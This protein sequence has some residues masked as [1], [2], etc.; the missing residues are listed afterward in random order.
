[1]PS[2]LV[3]KSHQLDAADYLAARPRAL[4]ADPPGMMKTL[5]VIHGMALA[6]VEHPLIVC[7][8]VV[9]THWRRSLEDYCNTYWPTFTEA[10]C[11]VKSY[12]EIVR[13]GTR[14][15]AD[16]LLTRDMLHLDEFHFCKH[17]SAQRTQ[18]LLGRDGYA[19]NLPIV[20]GTSGTPMDKTPT[21]I[22]T[23]LSSFFPALA[24]E[25]GVPSFR[26][27]VDRF[28]VWEMRERRGKKFPHY[29]P[30]TKEPEVFAELLSRMWLRRDSI[31]GVPAIF[32]VLRLDGSDHVGLDYTAQSDKIATTLG[33]A[34]LGAML[35]EEA[36]RLVMQDPETAR[37]RR[38]LG[39]HKVAPV[40]ALVTSE[41][42]DSDEKICVFAHHRSVL[43]GLREGLAKFGVAYIDGSVP[44]AARDAEIA[45]FI[46]E[47]E[48][49][50]FIGQN[51]A[52]GTGL[53]GLQKSGARRMLLVE[54][55]YSAVLNTQLA[56]RLAR[57]GQ[58][59]STVIAQM[60]AL[61]GTLDEGIV[62]LF[63]RETQFLMEAGL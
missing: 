57:F 35:D 14:M 53:D 17:A 9:R 41:L 25:Y 28:A 52:C 43:A 3:L 31:P 13:G 23:I 7:P 51:D 34:D 42:T 44:Q 36:I 16:L 18:L 15:Q 63:H 4:L 29:F 58:E 61:A 54:P 46:N 50:I 6:G 21:N 24:I 12:D 33:M 45:R 11:V 60:I 5:S 56:A 39:E 8:A 1:M 32:E 27:F 2:S 48:T 55:A 47:P 10:D 26:K 49:R 59:H 22:W 20:W 19:K 30:A 40:V 62:R 37:A 38:R